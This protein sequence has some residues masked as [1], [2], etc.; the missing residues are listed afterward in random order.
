MNKQDKHLLSRR[1]FVGKA[2]AAAAGF[3][4]VPRF[5]LGGKRPDGSRYLAPSDMISL[6]FIGTGKQGK[7]LTNSFLSTGETRIVAISEVYKAKAQLT[8]DRIKA[9]YEKSTEAGGYSDIPV[10][11][12][13]RELLARKGCR[14]RGDCYP[15]PLA[16][17]HGRAGRRSREGYLL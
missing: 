6:G 10:Y 8:L 14:C 17:G 11:N 15:R 3:M 9:H 2:A 4:I 7:G 13:F 5:V 1:N 12:D 16:R